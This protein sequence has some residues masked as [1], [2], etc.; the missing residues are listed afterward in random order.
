MVFFIQMHNHFTFG[1]PNQEIK[2][3]IQSR[4]GNKGFWYGSEKNANPILFPR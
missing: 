1:H 2:L 3:A 4:N